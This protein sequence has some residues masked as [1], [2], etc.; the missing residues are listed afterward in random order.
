MTHEWL[1]KTKHGFSLFFGLHVDLSL[2]IERQQYCFLD[3]R[4]TECFNMG[5]LDN[6]VFERVLFASLI[7]NH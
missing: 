4:L 2:E 1:R 3:K 7:Q 6:K 5:E